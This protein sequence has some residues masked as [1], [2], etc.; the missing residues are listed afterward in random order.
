MIEQAFRQISENSWIGDQMFFHPTSGILEDLAQGLPDDV[1]VI[2]TDELFAGIDYQ[3][4]NLGSTMGQ[5]VFQEASDLADAYVNPCEVVVLDEVPNDISVVAGIVTEQF[6]TPLA[7]INVLSQNRGTPNMGLKGAFNDETWRALEGKWVELT[8]G[9][10]EWTLSE[11]DAETGAAFCE[12]SKPEPLDLGDMD[13]S[14]QEIVDGVDVLDLTLDLGDALDKAIPAFGGKAS[15]YG[16]LVH[17]GPEVPVPT[18]FMIP[19]YFYDQFMTDNGFWTEV[20]AML[21]DPDFQTD[22]VVRAAE[23]EDLQARMQATPLDPAFESLVIAKMLTDFPGT[24][25]R[26]RSSTTAEDLGSFTGAGLYES[27]SGDPADPTR[28]VSE[29]ILTVW[30]SVWGPRA[31]EE[32]DWYGIDHRKVGMAV[33]SHRSFP[34]EESNGVAI[35]ANIFDSTGLE[36][37][38]YVNA[39]KGDVSVVIPEAGVISDQF[40]YFFD[41]PG[42]PVTY[43]AHSTEVADGETVL[44][45]EEIYTLGVALAAIRTHFFPVYGADGGFYGMDTEWKFDEPFHEQGTG[46]VQLWLKQARPYPGFGGFGSR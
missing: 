2:T 15:H 43:L 30:S 20:D 9:A 32:R 5:L 3:P 25:M 44:T 4:L 40:L 23:L 24:R 8:V 18:A 46:E 17:I 31:Y 33:L 6:Q 10:F 42:Q 16:A 45:E 36:P 27:Q 34:D 11:V 22:A 35:T 21:A 29:A 37:G 19:V 1:P 38:F 12:A 28:P 41:S 39:Q 13:L 14:V 7:H 26:F